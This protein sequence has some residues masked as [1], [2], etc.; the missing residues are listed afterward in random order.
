MEEI[1]RA[2]NVEGI[3][4][5]RL[6]RVLEEPGID[7]P[8]VYVRVRHIDLGMV[9]QASKPYQTVAAVKRIVPRRK[10]KKMKDNASLTR[11]GTSSLSADRGRQFRQNYLAQLALEQTEDRDEN[12]ELEGNSQ[13]DTQEVLPTVDVPADDVI[14]V[15][16]GHVISCGLDLISSG[17]GIHTDQELK[18]S[19]LS[20]EGLTARSNI[21]NRERRHVKAVKEWAQGDG[22]GTNFEISRE[23]GFSEA[24]EQ[25][26]KETLYPQ[27]G[28]MNLSST[29]KRH[30]TLG[31]QAYTTP[32]RNR[33]NVPETSEE[34]EA[35]FF[36]NV[37][38]YGIQPT[39]LSLIAPHNAAFYLETRS[40]PKPLTELHN[41]ENLENDLE[42]LLQ[43]SKQFIE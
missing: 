5:T 16:M 18:S 39:I 7:A 28:E 6:G 30:G 31:E 12:H 38:N 40:L 21:T 20:L 19:M 15:V 25:A 41:D 1:R 17:K 32:R 23:V 42:E 24:F 36:A 2:R 33:A 14:I 13:T 11:T 29:K 3:Y 4:T 43:R 8:Q 27:P 9:K 10:K 26:D 22:S 35:N 37:S 34:E